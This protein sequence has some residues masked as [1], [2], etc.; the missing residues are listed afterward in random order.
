MHSYINFINFGYILHEMCAVS[1]EKE[2]EKTQKCF[3]LEFL[4]GNH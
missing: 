4:W 3:E 1:Y 2:E